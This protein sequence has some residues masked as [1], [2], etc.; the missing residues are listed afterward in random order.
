MKPMYNQ[1]NQPNIPLY[2]DDPITREVF[3][4][5]TQKVALEM[6]KAPT[7]NISE[8]E[9]SFIL[10]MAAPGFQKDD[11]LVRL[12][13][14]ALLVSANKQKSDKQQA[15]KI[16]YQE[17]IQQNFTRI[18]QLPMQMISTQYIQASYRAGILSIEFPK[19]SDE[20]SASSIDIKV[21]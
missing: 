6:Q 14:G 9:T 3:Q 5:Q 20:I 7:A 15:S 1:S 11:F 10:E 2:F 16:L 19:K 17:H 8:T 4:W 13:N 12:E 21:K 18:F